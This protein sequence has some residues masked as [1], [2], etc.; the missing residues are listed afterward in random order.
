MK[1]KD[2]WNEFIAESGRSP[3][4]EYVDCFY[5]G[6][7]EKLANEL[8]A[9][10]LSG[11]KCATTSLLYDYERDGADI[12]KKNDLNVITDW[13]GNPRCVIETVDVAVLAF[14]EMTFDICMR[15]GEHEC[16]EDWRRGH[17]RYFSEVLSEYGMEFDE[18]MTV[19]FEDFKM[20]Y[21]K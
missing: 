9:L 11:K 5:F 2:F 7:N 21:S 15:E 13:A 8:L 18:H 14:N 19:V 20:V 4:T 3:S 10:V 12:P 16:L 1:V 17:T 6:N